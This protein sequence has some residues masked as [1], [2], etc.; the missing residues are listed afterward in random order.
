MLRTAER[1]LQEEEASGKLIKIPLTSPE[2]DELLAGVHHFATW[3]IV[4][5]PDSTSPV[6]VV[7]DPSRKDRHSPVTTRDL[8]ESLPDTMNSM[9]NA[10]ILLRLHTYAFSIDIKSAWHQ[11]ELVGDYPKFNL[12]LSY[13]DLVNKIDPVLIVKLVLQFGFSFANNVL[14]LAIS[15]FIEPQAKSTF[16]KW[17]LDIEIGRAHV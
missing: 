15:K 11:I 2:S 14:E 10:L 8:L 1:L 4:F 9:Y 17:I 6:R 12:L 5:N 16:V 7:I 13:Q 3:S